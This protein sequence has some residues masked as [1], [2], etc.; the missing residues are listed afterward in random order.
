MYI[1]TYIVIV[2]KYIDIVIIITYLTLHIHIC[3][4]IYVHVCRSTGFLMEGFPSSADELQFLASKGRFPDAAV[5][6]Q[7]SIG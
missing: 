1:C 5:I 4:F 7:V 3:M 6:M 2:Y